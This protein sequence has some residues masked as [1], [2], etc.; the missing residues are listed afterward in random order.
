MRISYIKIFIII[1]FAFLAGNVFSQQKKNDG[2]RYAANSVLSTGNWYKIKTNQ[3]SFYKLT[4]EDLSKMGLSDPSKV[5]VYGY[6]GNLL[7][8]DFSKPYIDDL[9]ELPIWMEKGDDNVFGSG[10]YIIFYAQGM[11]KWVFEKSGRGFIHENNPY[12]TDAFFFVTEG[13]GGKRIENATSS[14]TEYTK[15]VDWFDDYA[16]H[17]KDEKNLIESGREFYGESFRIN[18]SQNFVFNTPGILAGKV[19][20][21]NFVSKTKVATPLNVSINGVLTLSGNVPVTVNRYAAASDLTL[22]GPWSGTVSGQN[23]VSVNYSGVN[24]DNTYLNYITL[25]FTRR[26]QPYDAVTFFRNLES[27]NTSTQYKISNANSGLLVF[28]VT[29]ELNPQKIQVSLS[30][31]TGQFIYNS[32]ALE[33]FAIVDLTKQIPTPEVIGKVDNQDLHALERADMVIIVQPTLEHFANQLAQI[34]FDDS[35]L[36]SLVVNPEKIYNEFSSGKPDATAY[37]RFMKMFYDRA[38][39]EEEKPKY[40]LLFGDGVY[41]NRLIESGKWSSVN[42]SAFLLTFQSYQSLSQV[43]SYVT[44]DYFGFLDDDEG[45]EIARDKLDIGIGRFPVRKADEAIGVINKIEK[46]I[47]D[48]DQGIWKNNLLFLADDAIAGSNSPVSEMVHITDSDELAEKVNKDKPQFIV[49]KLY[50]DAF[51]RVETGEG[52]R[53]PDA[54]KKLFESI[55]NG[56]L[57]LN[58]MGHGSTRDWTHEYILKYPD[59]ENMTNTRLPVWITATCDFSRFDGEDMSGGE[60]ALLNPRGGAIAL[61]ST[62]RLVYASSNMLLATG[63]FKNI[64]TKDNGKPLRLG[65]IMKLAKRES[66]LAFDSNK[67]NF[68][69]LGDPALRLSYPDEYPKV[70]VTEINSVEGDELGGEPIVFNALSTVRIKG[71][72]AYEDGSIDADFNGYIDSKIFDSRQQLT[73]RDNANYDL[74]FTYYDY[75]NT[76][77]N[78]MAEVVNGEFEYTFVVPK[79][80]LY[81]MEDYGKMSFYAYQPGGD[82]KAHGYFSNYKIYG[83][84]PN[85]PNDVTPPEITKLYLNSESFVSGDKTN[86]TPM[87]IA[88]VYDDTGINLSGWHGHE[89]TVTIEGISKNYL[90]TYDVTGNFQNIANSANSGLVSFLI[91]ELEN[92]RYKLTFRVWDVS[93]NSATKELEFV[94]TDEFEPIINEFFIYGNPAKDITRFVLTTNLPGSELMVTF[95]VYN[96][97]GNLIWSHQEKSAS[98]NNVREIEYEWNLTSRDGSRLNP[99]IYLVRAS[100]TSA[101]GIFENAKGRKLIITKQ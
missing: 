18:N 14:A 97:A 79:D 75:T 99:G 8:P 44:D 17:E 81:S 66:N 53:Y 59:I 16:I 100:V 92:G 41:D 64:F 11:V 65:D 93:N 20:T 77:Y 12:S 30:G 26:L 50:M 69:L 46:Y 27:V 58:F 89:I 95:S 3:K 51:E 61:F 5:K 48:K 39:T 23:T 45:V 43:G 82:K 47:K 4:Y 80:I 83:T 33:E 96:M 24:L 32:N 7:D 55:E 40:L 70:V 38:E 60:M 29:N 49:N 78:G 67:L 72:I 74:A 86:T 10:D 25:Q 15:T 36:T 1:I 9:P 98:G 37:R 76:I 85:A 42:T 73:T 91:P 62:V 68:A 34:H 63:L 87:L 90:K 84:D 54:Q 57:V 28:N 94:V 6:G 88:E 2:S 52:G 101:N 56:Q 71:K 13:D 31:S 21:I 22:S 19:A 35:G